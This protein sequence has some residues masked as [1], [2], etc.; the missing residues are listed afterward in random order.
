MSESGY[1]KD[2]VGVR[3]LITNIIY[4][5][6]LRPTYRTLPWVDPSA[7]AGRQMRG[8]AIRANLY[9]RMVLILLTSTPPL[10]KALPW[11]DQSAAA[12]RQREGDP[13]R[14][15]SEVRSIIV[16]VCAK[17]DS[18]VNREGSHHY[19]RVGSTYQ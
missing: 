1:S 11:V 19:T 13:C 4:P 15:G 6:P 8:K 16:F 5:P 12:D 7:P 2:Y 17:G 10:Q 3:V 18:I 9:L 14:R